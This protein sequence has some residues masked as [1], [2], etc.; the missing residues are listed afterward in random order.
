MENE[1]TVAS[2]DSTGSLPNEATS[3]ETASPS[4]E[5]SS[6]MEDWEYY[7]SENEYMD[8]TEETI[9]YVTEPV[10]IDVIQDT[11]SALVNAYLF[12]SFLLCGTLVGI[13]LLRGRY[14][15]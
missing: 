3:P 1:F 6:S 7:L 13:F 10:Y 5:A 9:A 4:S 14:G 11:G 2:S 8:T 15:T 12:G